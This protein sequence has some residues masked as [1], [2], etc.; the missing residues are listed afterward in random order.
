[1]LRSLSIGIRENK[2][3]NLPCSILSSMPYC[4]RKVFF[5]KFKSS[6]LI[7]IVF[8]DFF[9]FNTILRYTYP[10]ERRILTDV[11]ENE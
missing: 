5:Y 11:E 3:P 8:P 1:M 4:L 9:P 2:F 7:E 6:K 10:G